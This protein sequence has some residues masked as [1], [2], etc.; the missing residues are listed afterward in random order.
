MRLLKISLPVPMDT[1]SGV[2]VGGSRAH[3]GEN[4]ANHNMASAFELSSNRSPVSA[5]G[6]L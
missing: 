4:V 3:P 6:N 2:V 1:G 5:D